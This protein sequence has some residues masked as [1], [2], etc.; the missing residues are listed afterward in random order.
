MATYHANNSRTGYSTGSSIN[1]ANVSNL[2]QKWH[3]AVSAP[4]SDQP[5]VDNGVVYWGD[6]SG[7]MHATSVSGK[8]L[9]STF[10]GTASN[11]AACP[12][13]LATQGIVSSPTVGTLNGRNLVWVGGGAGQLVAL[14]ASTGAIVWSTRL[15]KPPEYVTWTSPALYNGSI[16]EGVASFNDCPDIDGT[17]DRVDA[18]TG[19]I[20]AVYHPRV[21]TGCVGV[22]IWSSPAPDPTNN[23]IYVST[24]PAY[25]KSDLNKG[26]AAPDQ[27]AILQLDPITLALKSIWQVPPSQQVF[28]GD[29]GA[30]PM[31]FS[32][33]IDG[34][35]HQLVGAENKNG[36]YY[37]LDRDDLEAGP[38]WSYTAEN[39]TTIA[40]KPCGGV[41]TIS[42]SAWAGPGS[43]VVVAGIALK[44]SSC[45]GTLGAL[46]PGTGQ[47]EWQVPLQG[48]VLG[49]VTEAPG[50]VAVGA[51]SRVD[52]LSSATGKLLFS[53]KERAK[54]IKKGGIYGAPVG[55]FWGP[56]SIAG[57]SLY[58]SNQDGHLRAFSLS[59]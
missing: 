31:L 46:D 4:I 39:A 24:G 12:Y 35:S 53:Y 20:Q 25:Q 44:G 6:W 27:D 15:G 36:I 54:A 26:C 49:A 48:A 11:P 52:V 29:F 30:S 17:F 18:A 9:W 14:N 22:G 41:N 37:A 42:S 50:L 23:S 7:H 55:W 28:D 32:A 13:H 21:P 59:S 3:I 58:A 43:A 34:T 10:L 56:L 5:I 51:G 1:T 8:P 45:I 2:F 19:A 38:V 40:S 57:N 16:Y 47:S 33:T